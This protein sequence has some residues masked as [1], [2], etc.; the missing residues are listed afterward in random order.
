MPV[1]EIMTR[2][3]ED[4]RLIYPEADIGRVVL[5]GFESVESVVTYSEHLLQ[6]MISSG[7]VLQHPSRES[8]GILA[9]NS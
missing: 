2:V 4:L 8:A 7:G 5:P 9:W 3:R 6:R 1:D